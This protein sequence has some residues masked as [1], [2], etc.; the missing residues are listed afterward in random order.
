[1]AQTTTANLSVLMQ[2]Y[3][4]KKFLEKVVQN[5][6][7]AQFATEKSIPANSGKIIDFSRYLQPA[8][9]TTALTE[10]T[11]PTA[12]AVTAE[13]VTATIAE[14]GRVWNMSS[15]VSL[16]AI[17]PELE[18]RTD[19]AADDASATLDTLVR[20]E[21]YNA[22]NIQRVAN[23]A[24]DVNLTASSI[25]TTAEIRKVLRTLQANK[26]KPMDDGFYVG[27]VGPYTQYDIM[28]DTTWVN[29]HT[30][31]DGDNLYK[32]EIGKLFGIRFVMTNNQRVD[33]TG[34]SSANVY[35]N[36]FLGKESVGKVALDGNNSQII[37][38][39]PGAN[40]TSNALNMF[41]TFGWKSMFVAKILQQA[42]L[43]NLRSG[44]TQ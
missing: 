26:A 24:A 42:Y 18:R 8:V 7:H 31:K 44:A 30:Y 5:F 40:D 12:L 21:M 27:I 35:S 36:Y 4:D 2:T 3:Y 34:A 11:N 33:A 13:N 22:T 38:K 37:V 14:Y 23:A 9:S 29:A 15:L 10:G 16:T 43:M 17:D 41:S 19:I 28:A 32:G 1:M 25:V 6:I 20:D 39:T